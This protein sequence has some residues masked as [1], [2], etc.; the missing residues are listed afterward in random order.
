M[1]EAL[2]K[3]HVDH[4]VIGGAACNLLG[5]KRA[6]GDLDF[7]VGVPGHEVRHL[8]ARVA[9]TDKRFEQVGSGIRLKGHNFPIEMLPTDRLTWPVPLRNGVSSVNAKEVPGKVDVLSSAA[10]YFNKALRVRHDMSSTRPQTVVKVKT[11]LA[12]MTFLHGITRAETFRKIFHMYPGDKQAKIAE[13]VKAVGQKYK[14][15]ANVAV[16]IHAS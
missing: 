12:D 6:T 2:T 13:A 1:S 7:V 3:L 16:F 4:A 9:S 5:S 8:K 11:D 10:I 15:L 14:N